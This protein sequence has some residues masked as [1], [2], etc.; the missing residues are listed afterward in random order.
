VKFADLLKFYQFSFRLKSLLWLM[1]FAILMLARS[2]A[3]QA[4][5][6]PSPS[7]TKPVSATSRTTAASP[8]MVLLGLYTRGYLGDDR[9]VKQEIQAIDSWAGKQVSLAGMFF[10]IEDSNP[11]YNIPVPLELLRKKGYTAFINL[12]SRRSMAEI[13][14]GE[15][16][17][18]FKQLAKAFA[19]WS[20][21]NGDR[22]AFIAPFP[23]MNGSWESYREDPANF[24]LA[25]QRIQRIFAEQ[26]VSKNAV[27]WV[28]APNGWSK[29]EHRFEN[30]YPGD[31]N[32]DIVAFS[33]YNW[34]FCS[35]NASAG[36][37]RAWDGPDKIYAPYVQRM[38][39]MAPN[40]PI[41]IAQTATS[42]LSKNGTNPV[43]KDQWMQESYRYLANAG[44]RAVLYFNLDKECDWALYRGNG[45][46]S[47]GYAAI[48]ANPD[49][50]YVAPS[51]L[52]RMNLAQPR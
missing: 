38:K 2:P 3:L 10:D 44:V 15:V 5:G 39:T 41:F 16:D 19:T 20:N 47:A 8:P 9:V 48:V 17:G 1:P 50:V 26:G 14:R 6:K 34:G 42:S 30:Y 24:K 28:F 25:Y 29:P 4:L 12:A 46:N 35:A 27:R 13:A 32:T 33:A 23:E 51:D 37:W 18:N 49:F 31:A 45:Q 43:A 40:K 7:S 11:A 22:M 52:A 21:K 36:Q